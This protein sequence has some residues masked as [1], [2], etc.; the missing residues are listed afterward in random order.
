MTLFAASQGV[1]EAVCYSIDSELVRKTQ[2]NLCHQFLPWFVSHRAT[3]C[4]QRY[5]PFYAD[6]G[7]LN[8]G[9]A[10]K[11]CRRTAELLQV[12]HPSPFGLAPAL[13]LPRLL[14]LPWRSF[15]SRHITGTW[16]EAGPGACAPQDAAR[17]GKKLLFYTGPSPQHKANAAVL[18]RCALGKR[19]EVVGS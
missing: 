2:G 16:L 19:V 7:P 12:S 10:F 18:V 4:A 6:F 3:H 17:L 8:L 13:K 1:Q 5:E 9:H 11:Y 15:A 14:N